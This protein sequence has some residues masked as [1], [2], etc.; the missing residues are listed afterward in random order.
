MKKVYDAARKDLGTWEWKDGHNPKVLKYFADVGHDWVKDDE[1]AWCAAF[2]GS[3]L[4]EAG[5][6]HTGKLNARSYLDWGQSVEIGSA[7]PGDVVILWRGSPDSWKG[8]V[9]FFVRFEGEDVI[10]LGGNQNNQ[11]NERSYPADRIL[12]VRRMKERTKPTQSKTVQ[13]SAVTM[14]GGAGTALSAVSGLDQYAQY[15]VL[16]FAGL[17]V[18]AGLF[19]MRERLKAWASGWR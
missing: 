16:G 15:I 4:K 3:K 14:A 8:H 9:G 1:T 5:L 7:E 11:V 10:L 2:V 18:L 6:P 13:A 19:I 12:G 17:V